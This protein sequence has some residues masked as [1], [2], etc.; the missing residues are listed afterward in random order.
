MPPIETLPPNTPAPQNVPAGRLPRNQLDPTQGLYV[1]SVQTNFVQIPVMVKSRDGRRVDGLLAKDFTVLENGKPQKLTYFTSDPLLLSVAIV[2]DLG[3]ADV[4]LQKVN[5]TY[6]SLVG[7]FSPYDEFALYTY[8]STVSQV[9]DFT[10]NPA[11][12]NASLDEMK[13]VRGHSGPPVLDG[14][15]AMG[16]TVN[17]APVGGPIIAPVNTPPKEAFVLNDAI[18]RAAL[19][20]SK[21]DRARRRVILVISD[22]RERGSQASYKE[23]LRVL[24]THGI[25]LKAVVLDMG[26][27]PG[28]K[29]AEKIH[30]LF[31]QGYDDILPKYSSATGS[32][33]I[34]TELTRNTIE[35]A[36]VE[37]ASEARNQY[38]LGY[39]AKPITGASPYRS[40]EILVD[41]KGLKIYAKDGYY[42]IPQ[43]RPDMAQPSPQ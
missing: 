19:D 13:T 7:A 30:H 22:G 35:D 40:I 42:F 17:G 14:P 5:Q 39:S 33:G 8:S 28:F 41:K 43:A 11:R 18:L 15:L 21:R 26:A 24:Q 12:L 16:P 38:T 1:V 25:Q 37:V 10:N 2:L 27:L 29:Q 20:L 23:V 6:G 36:Y 4:A 3:M 31:H 9:T 34:F 32:G